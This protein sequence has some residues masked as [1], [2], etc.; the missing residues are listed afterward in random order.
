M[1]YRPNNQI[2]KIARGKTA[3]LRCPHS[4]NAVIIPA[5]LLWG[6]ESLVPFSKT[7]HDSNVM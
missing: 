1:A 4:T 7:T 2:D 3:E 5:N 6:S